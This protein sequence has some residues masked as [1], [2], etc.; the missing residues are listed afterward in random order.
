MRVLVVSHV[1]MYREG[2]ADV[3][4]RRGQL[5]SVRTAADAPEA[6]NVLRT[7]PEGPHIVVLDMA[8][9][10]GDLIARRLAG[11]VM[12]LA[13][14]VAHREEDV[15]ACAEAG[16]AGFL[17][18]EASLD[19]LVEALARLS[20]GETLCSPWSAGV[21]LRRVA[22]LAHAGSRPAQAP[23]LTSRELEIVDLLDRGFSNKQIAQRLC[24]ELPTVKNHVHH[25]L[26]KLGVKRRGEVGALIRGAVGDASVARPHL[27]RGAV[28]DA[29]VARY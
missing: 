1:A 3:L 4:L 25:I 14:G 11:N 13:V 10:D 19:D 22:T 23:S 7:A 5:E 2:I 27:I 18:T 8:M 9:P 16:V 12:V 29:S 28:G 20:R 17:T 21:L 26:D 6:L 15:I 24:I